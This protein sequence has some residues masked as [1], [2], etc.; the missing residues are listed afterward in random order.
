MED[1]VDVELAS[2]EIIVATWRTGRGLIEWMQEQPHGPFP[3]C[4]YRVTDG[5]STDHTKLDIISR[6]FKLKLVSVT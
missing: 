3:G 2:C 1:V 5:K 4:F 6:C